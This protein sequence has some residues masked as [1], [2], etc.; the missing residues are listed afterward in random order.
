MKDSKEVFS[1]EF[2]EEA[3]I[4]L[5]EIL[6]KY[7]RYWPWFFL[8]VVVCLT[9][10][11]L[12]IYTTPKL[13]ESEARFKIIDDAQEMEMS[14]DLQSIVGRSKINLDNEIAVLTSYRLLS[15]VVEE[16]DLDIVYSWEG[17]LRTTQLW[18]V[19]FQ[20]ER[21]ADSVNE[22]PKPS[23][24]YQVAIKKNHFQ[25]T[26]SNGG[27]FNVS[28]DGNN[29]LDKMPFNIE[30]KE[31][32]DPVKFENILFKVNFTSLKSAVLGLK[33]GLDVS[34]TSKNS[35]ILVLKLKG[36]QPQRTEE[37]LNVI[38][39]KFNQDGI[40][41]RQLVSYN[42]IK[43]INE[44][45]KFLRKELDSIEQGKEQFSRER[46]LS[47]LEADAQTALEKK[48]AA[49]SK[50]F[51]VETQISLVKLLRDELSSQL[52]DD[53]EYSLLPA[54]IGINSEPLNLLVN[55]YNDGFLERS[56]YLAT[57]AGE[58]NSRVKTLE[59]EMDA[60]RGNVWTTIASQLTKLND[61]LA[62]L[63]KNRRNANAEYS[64]IPENDRILRQ[65]IRQ[66]SIKEE[67]FIMLL[68]KREEAEISNAVTSPS[69][70]VVDYALT[71]NIPVSPNTKMILLS[72][73][74]LAIGI[75]FG[76]I[77][78]IF[79]LDS[80]VHDR[81]DVEK[82]NPEIPV[83][84][85]IPF[86]E[87]GKLFNTGD[88]RSILAEA[89]RILAT[90]VNYLVGMQA[91]NNDHAKVIF[92]TSSV[93]GEGKTFVAI[94]SA[95]AF[96]SMNK[97]VLLVGSDLRNP[98]LHQY[99]NFGKNH[100][101]GLSA[102]LFDQNLEFDDCLTKDVNENCHI[103]FSGVVPPNA[104]QLLASKRFEEF[105]QIAKEKYDYVVFDLAPTLLVTDTLIISHYA[106][107]TIYLVRAGV[108]EKEILKFPKELNRKGKLSNM[109][110]LVNNVGFKKSNRYGYGYKYNYSYNYGY[111]YG[112][113]EGDDDT[114]K[115]PWYKRIF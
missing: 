1:Y 67:L 53:S 38:V 82:I 18:N 92:V 58:N 54:D 66:Q 36:Q 106:D 59:N 71:K 46:G 41:D 10:A 87:G 33:N 72:A 115:K 79:L 78:I 102:F 86:I 48:E 14:F 35:E 113:G 75:P 26:D 114:V 27:V 99:F 51:Q 95:L 77:Y 55:Q 47:Y 37:I 76:I 5:K 19:P 11:V 13:Y 32:L 104:P 62:Q 101:N 93:K 63:E 50:V 22:G 28:L 40:N 30:L 45:F 84:G 21:V 49:E 31:G 110:F 96:A 39:D 109:A 57:S 80:K 52:K 91:N 15:K 17:N 69:I 68:K 94:N 97:K 8:S 12:K 98:Q 74:F 100:N 34:P 25:I 29:M 105:V 6:Y 23:G 107:A 89:F 3:T 4:N 65:I 43:F 44:R 42:T 61:E 83:I 81:V 88:D 111:S 85:E 20:I 90:N 108:T 112:Y 64:Q 60:L 73:F 9:L 70:K 2:Q 16:L 7:L 24:I 103:C 56:K